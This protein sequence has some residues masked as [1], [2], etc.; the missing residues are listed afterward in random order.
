[1]KR[2]LIYSAITYLFGAVVMAVVVCKISSPINKFGQCIIAGDIL[3]PA[4]AWPM[5]LVFQA[6]YNSFTFVTSIAILVILAWYL[7]R[8]R[9]SK[10]KKSITPSDI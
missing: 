7:I 9:K 3:F 10:S 5:F 2:V 6:G 1:M 8:S 4:F